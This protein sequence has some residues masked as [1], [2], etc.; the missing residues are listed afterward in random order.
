MPMRTPMLLLILFASFASAQEPA[1]TSAADD[2]FNKAVLFGKKFFDLKEYISAYEQFA[3]ADSLRPD[4]PAVLYNMAVVLARAGRYAEAQV[5]VDRYNQL[6]PAGA[7]KPNVTK[8]QLELEF[9]RELQKK[10]QADQEYGELFNRGKFLYAKNDLEGALKAF[11]DAEQQRPSDPAAVFN[12]AVVHEKQGEFAKAVERFRRF[13][14]LESDPDQKVGIDQRIFAMETEIEDM[15]SKIVCAFCGH[16]LPAGVT[17]CHRC[18][19]GP[20]LASAV[21]NSRPCLEGATATRS[22]YYSDGRLAKNEPL[23]CLHPN[24]TMRETLRYTP[25]RQ[26]S[27]QEARKSEGWTYN[28]EVIQGWSDKEGNQVRYVQGADYLDQIVSA[29]TGELLDF[30]A[31][32]AAD[33]LWLLDREDVMI[34]GTKYISRY[35]Y[36]EK[37]RIARQEVTYQNVSACNH[38]IAMT[39]D[40]AYQNEALSGVNIKGGYDGYAAEGAPRTDWQA[41]VVYAYDPN[42][43]VSKEELTVN[44]FTKTYAQRPHGALREEVGKVYASMRPKRP[45]ENVIRLGDICGTAGTLMVANY[46]DLRPFYAMSPNLALALPLGVVRA[47]V[48]F[49]Y[50]DA[51]SLR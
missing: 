37:N 24:G 33:G 18:W 11:Q 27:I 23:V 28:G 21:W 32:R 40:Y 10:R 43:R 34:E 22:T 15:R 47:T 2:E 31:H 25:A 8:L 3:K 13:S 46:I 4:D 14:E 17:W 16:K 20:Y 7:E 48:T 39:A 41:A 51:F 26:R 9:H 42:G 19:H 36:D 38:L 12:Q 1:V 35:A 50:P 49:T 30:E 5:K 45:I 29:G 44:G 6:Y